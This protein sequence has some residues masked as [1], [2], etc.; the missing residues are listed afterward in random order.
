MGCGRV[1]GVVAGVAVLLALAAMAAPVGAVQEE[2]VAE[3][4]FLVRDAP[5]SQTQFQMIVQAGCND[6]PGGQCRGLAHYLEHLVLT[7]RNREHTDIAVRLFPDVYSNGW[8]SARATAYVHS[9]PAR[10]G[11]PKADLEK[12]FA[13]YAA[14]LNDF[15]IGDAEAARERNVVLQ[16]HDW[17]VTSSPF[18]RFDRK[19]DRELLPDHPAGQW[20]IG[21]RESIQS[22]AVAE[23]QAFHRSWYAVNNAYF[24]VRADI[25]AADLKE[26]ADKALAGL[27]PKQLPAHTAANRRP[28]VA[29][30]RKDFREADVQVTRPTVSY[31]KLLRAEDSDTAAHRAARAVLGGFLRSRLPSSPHHALVDTSQLA[32]STPSISIDR[33]A[34]G[35]LVLRVS[36]EVAPDAAPEALLAAIGAYVDGLAQAPPSAESVARLKQR[37]A[38]GRANEDHDPA[39]VYS[40]LVSWLGSRSS[41]QE[42]LA[43][44]KH[45][46]DVTHAD[47]VASAAALSAPGRIVTGTLLPATEDAK[48]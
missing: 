40:R 20:T 2:Q 17:R 1:R 16:E 22:L 29:I 33:V 10:D 5:G 12:L 7:G 25:S 44:P 9:L 43:W 47:V 48:R 14:R 13:F 38:D 46:A 30:E 28:D 15:A 23:A 8:T 18:R 39:L 45:I 4:I 31:R 19:L 6:E 37:I 26:I 24:V 35:T 42:Y 36:A 34:P 11:G 27:A 41:Y 3:R 32:A 21:T